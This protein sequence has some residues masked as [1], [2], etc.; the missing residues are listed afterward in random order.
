MVSSD[1]PKFANKIL[2]ETMIDEVI[3]E[4]EAHIDQISVH[5]NNFTATLTNYESLEL[6]FILLST[7][8]ETY[9][10]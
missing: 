4:Q 10:R 2:E 1:D 3:S 9:T 6:L 7:I 5:G 8:M